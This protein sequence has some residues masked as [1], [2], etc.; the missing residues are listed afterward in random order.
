MVVTHEMQFAR[1]V[2]ARVLFMD[3]GRILDD[4][5]PTAFFTNPRHARAM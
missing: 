4:G 2:G 5:P 3:G 1:G